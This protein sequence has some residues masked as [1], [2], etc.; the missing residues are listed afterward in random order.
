[1]KGENKTGGV[2]GAIPD[3][4]IQFLN[5]LNYMKRAEDCNKLRMGL[6]IIYGKFP[7]GN[8]GVIDPEIRKYQ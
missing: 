3:R 8:Y 1:M 6:Y 7:D 4:S 5:G 2:S